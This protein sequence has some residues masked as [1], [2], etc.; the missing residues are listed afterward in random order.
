MQ[1]LVLEFS[2]FIL[3]SLFLRTNGVTVPDNPCSKFFG[4]FEATSRF[5]LP[6]G[7]ILPLGTVF[8][9]AWFENDLSG[10]YIIEVNMSI[11]MKTDKVSKYFE[12]IAHN[13][14]LKDT[15]C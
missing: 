15:I 5:D 13:I 14:F 4:Y 3:V 11:P 9:V 12:Q 7:R 8:A 2:L 1:K 10:N 6:S